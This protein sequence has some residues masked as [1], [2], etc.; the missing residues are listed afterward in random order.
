MVTATAPTISA[1]EAMA[2]ANGFLLDH[3]PDRFCA[4]E[5]RLDQTSLVWRIP[6]LLS[7]AVIGPVGQVGEIIVGTESEEVL[8]YTPLEEMK[9]AAWVLIEQNR[10]KI[11]APVP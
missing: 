3:L 5:P 7:Y 1:F 10:E 9:A 11:E 6:V 2:T 8:S 4:G